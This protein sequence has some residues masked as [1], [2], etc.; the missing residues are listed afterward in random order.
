MSNY[1]DNQAQNLGFSI[2]L[3][4]IVLGGL[5]WVYYEYGDLIFGSSVGFYQDFPNER[6]FQL[7]TLND[8]GLDREIINWEFYFTEQSASVDL[9]LTNLMSIPN[10][11]I[12]AKRGILYEI[13]ISDYLSNVSSN[14]VL[15][16]Y[17]DARDEG[18]R[19]DLIF[20]M[21]DNISITAEYYDKNNQ[22]GVDIEVPRYTNPLFKDK[23]F[24]SFESLET[25][26]VFLFNIN[27]VAQQMPYSDIWEE[28]LNQSFNFQNAKI[29]YIGSQNDLNL[30]LS[31][32]KVGY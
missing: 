8:L 30:K 17:A 11:D 28:S 14:S 5:F 22:L 13:D 20:E 6:E 10:D 19:I 26:N 12:I 29:S 21:Q 32:L 18:V 27:G 3:G 9:N 23:I 24:V 1:Y 15:S 31:S 25:S 7:T 16:L 2:I 4:I